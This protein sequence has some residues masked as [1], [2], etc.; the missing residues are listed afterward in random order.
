MREEKCS[1]SW[2]M[3]NVSSG[4]TV[5]KKCFHCGKVS[6]CFTFHNKPPFEP[7]REGQHFW[8][9]MESDE[10]FHFDLKCTQ[11]GIVIK[12]SELVG[13]TRCTGCDPTCEVYAL[14]QEFE[15]GVTRVCIALGQRPIDERK[16][17]TEEK[18]AV[19]QDYLSQQS[20][21]KKSKIKIVDHQMIRDLAKCYAEPITD[22]DMLFEAD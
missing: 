18:I 20:K 3:A 15:Q 5:M 2:E 14:R 4:L 17:L 21:S 1:H 11:C 10:S 22:I 16:Q 7:S 19:L 8:N 12:L 13:L 6:A 9:F